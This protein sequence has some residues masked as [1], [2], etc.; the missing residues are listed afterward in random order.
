[1]AAAR[2]TVVT[3]VG[4]NRE[5]VI[6][7]ETGFIVPPENPAAIAEKT[8]FLLRNKRLAIEMGQAGQ[9]RAQTHFSRETMIRNYQELYESLI[10]NG[11][12]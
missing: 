3:D 9:R 10:G 8:L 12:V 5:I 2:P 1:M 11:L 6:Q 4:G 7:G